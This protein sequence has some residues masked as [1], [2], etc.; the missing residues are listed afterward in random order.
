M[1]QFLKPSNLNN[2]W[3]SGGD[4]IYPGDTKYATGWQVEIPPRQYFNEIDYKQD[5]MLAHLNQHGIPVWDNETEYQAGKSYTQGPTNGTIYQCILTN[6]NQNP[7]TDLT[8]TYWIIAFAAAGTFYTK[9]EA[10]TTFLGAA[11]NL[12]GLTNAATARKN[13]SVYSQ[14]QT[15]TKTEVDAK[16][17]VAS[18]AQA[19]AQVSNTVLISALRLADAFKGSNQ[20]LTSSG[21]QKLPGGLIVQWGFVETPSGLAASVEGSLPA[22]F[23]IPFPTGTLIAVSSASSQRI[24]SAVTTL[25]GNTG[26]TIGYRTLDAVALAQQLS[27]IAIGI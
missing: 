21:H 17:T 24:V 10:D 8:N 2:V 16:T 26:V 11:D 4:R 25:T 27:Y 19:Q 5:Q 7:E 15:Y 18:T 20:S 13:L 23:S 9:A 12:A 22:K 1:A 3:A 14:A 6:T